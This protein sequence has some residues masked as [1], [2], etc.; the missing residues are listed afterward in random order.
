MRTNIAYC[1]ILLRRL[2]AVTLSAIACASALFAETYTHSWGENTTWSL[3]T[4]DSTFIIEGNGVINGC[5][6]NIQIGGN[7]YNLKHL[8]KH[9][10]IGEGITAIGKDNFAECLNLTDIQWPSSIDSIGDSAFDGAAA[11]SSVILP[12]NLRYISSRAFANCPLLQTI[13]FPASVE[14]IEGGAFF[15]DPLLHFQVEDNHPHLCLLNGVLLS[16]DLHTIIQAQADISGEYIAPDSVKTIADYAFYDCTALSSIILPDGLGSIGSFAISGCSGLTT[17]SIPDNVRNIGKGAFYHNAN[18]QSMHLPEGLEV[19]EQSVLAGC[20]K[21]NAVNIPEGVTTIGHYAFSNDSA[22]TTMQIP[23]GVT[24]VGN[25]VFSNCKRLQT[26]DLPQSLVNMGSSVFDRCIALQSVTLHGNFQ[27]TS[28]NLFPFCNGL[29]FIACEAIDPPVLRY[30]RNFDFE[31][32]ILYVP[33][34]S[35]AAYRTADVWKDF[36]T[37]LPL[38]AMPTAVE[39]L[40]QDVSSSHPYKLLRDNRMYIDCGNYIY[41]VMGTPV[42]RSMT[43]I[44]D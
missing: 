37:I 25:E 6:R 2:F 44:H 28:G 23:E 11:L 14:K 36:A 34:E 30:L 21:L 40:Q 10:V 16:R 33:E 43:T 35:I 32:V 31:Q 9:L 12:A 38:S 24:Y 13:G 5:E 39:S 19:I 41:N 17:L 18:L 8:I 4:A 20:P 7:W 42:L 26:I 22:L 27:Y 3:N 1:H 15:G 29:Q